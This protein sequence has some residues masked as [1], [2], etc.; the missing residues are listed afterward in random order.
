MVR[1][2]YSIAES[3]DDARRTERLAEQREF[4]NQLN[5]D[6]FTA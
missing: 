2:G 3:T 4:Y 6:L 5:P 1:K